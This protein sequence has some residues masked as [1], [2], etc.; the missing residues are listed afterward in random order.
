[1]LII[2]QL[3]SEGQHAQKTYG[4]NGWQVWVGWEDAISVQW[5]SGKDTSDWV[6]KTCIIIS[7]Q[8]KTEAI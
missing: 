4:K 7:S 5:L 2:K 6:M 3:F 1:M 8:M